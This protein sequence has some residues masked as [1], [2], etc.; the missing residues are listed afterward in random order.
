L[1][2]PARRKP[3]PNTSGGQNMVMLLNRPGTLE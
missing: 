2:Q 1:L 3:R